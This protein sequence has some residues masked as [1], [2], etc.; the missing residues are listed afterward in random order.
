MRQF[1]Q[2]IVYSCRVRPLDRV[3]TA[4]YIAHRLQ[5]AGCESG[6]LFTP[7]AA[8]TVFAASR[9]V[10]RLINIICHKALMAAFGRGETSV[11]ASHVRR[12]IADTESVRGRWFWAIGARLLAARLT[13][14]GTAAASLSAMTLLPWI[15]R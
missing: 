2:R 10:P 1:K 3:A 8:D 11:N 7:T 5:K 15:H 14:L 9:G 6:A 12:A 13:A 4:S